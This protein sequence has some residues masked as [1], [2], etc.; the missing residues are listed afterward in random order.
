ME[1]GILLSTASAITQSC[2]LIR[3][4]LLVGVTGLVFAVLGF[5]EP[6]VGEI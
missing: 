6:E 3:L 5:V 2:M 1:L 4:A